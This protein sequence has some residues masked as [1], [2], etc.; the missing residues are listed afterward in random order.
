MLELGSYDPVILELMNLGINRSIA[1][2]IRPLLK[3]QED[4]S[5]EETLAKF[6]KKE[7][8]ALFKRY[9]KRAGF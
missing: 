9:L 3:F 5:I 1:I 6:D 2:K 8:P 7:M 4:M